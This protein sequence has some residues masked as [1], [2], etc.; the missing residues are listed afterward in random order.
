LVS[1]QDLIEIGSNPLGE[2]FILYDKQEMQ[3]D[4]KMFGGVPINANK[5]GV[6]GVYLTLAQDE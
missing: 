1:G 2:N 4:S 3:I 5:A 6:S